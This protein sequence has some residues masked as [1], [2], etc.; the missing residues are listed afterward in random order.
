[1]GCLYLEIEGRSCLV[2]N[3]DQGIM[4]NREIDLL[5]R[6][7]KTRGRKKYLYRF[8]PKATLPGLFQQI[9]PKQN[10]G[11]FLAKLSAFHW[12]RPQPSDFVP[13]KNGFYSFRAQID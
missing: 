8:P 11:N 7:T 13:I 9:I 6:M 2:E 1:M 3:V 4:Q 12:H 5:G 10:F